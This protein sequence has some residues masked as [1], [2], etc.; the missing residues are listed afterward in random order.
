MAHTLQSALKRGQE[1]RMVQIDFSAAFGK[2]NHR[3]IL[4][5]VGVGSVL[6]VLIQFLCNRSQYVVGDGCRSKL[7]NVVSGVP[8]VGV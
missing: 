4:C 6:S 3:G 8:Q 5:S 2:V 1:A 7:V